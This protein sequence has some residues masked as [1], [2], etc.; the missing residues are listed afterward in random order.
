MANHAEHHKR[1]SRMDREGST[2]TRTRNLITAGRFDDLDTRMSSRINRRPN[3]M[4]E[5]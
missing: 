3:L 5:V 1:A 4:T 2:R